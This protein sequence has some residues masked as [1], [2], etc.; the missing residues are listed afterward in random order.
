MS[1]KC[2]FIAINQ[3]LKRN[4]V[5]LKGDQQMTN[6]IINKAPLRP[7]LQHQFSAVRTK[8][9][10]TVRLIQSPSPEKPIST[11]VYAG[12]RVSTISILEKK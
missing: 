12:F 4:I 2:K 7:E 3:G 10:T 9:T 5:H 6:F 1:N 11:R 8:Y